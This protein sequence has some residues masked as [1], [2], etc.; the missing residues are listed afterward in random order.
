MR[1]SRIS[2]PSCCR[3]EKSAMSLRAGVVR[4]SR[5]AHCLLFVI[6]VKIMIV[7]V[8]LTTVVKP[9]T[10]ESMIYG[11]L[12]RIRARTHHPNRYREIPARTSLERF[13]SSVDPHDRL[14][15]G[16]RRGREGNVD[17]A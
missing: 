12:R 15:G 14:R 7:Q 11:D 9:G 10:L 1:K 5:M 17:D 3:V 13:A 6:F 2:G 16:E 4:W 8:Y